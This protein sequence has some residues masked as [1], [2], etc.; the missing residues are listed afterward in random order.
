MLKLK[1]D[2]ASLRFWHK[3]GTQI[4]IWR[5]KHKLKAIVEEKPVHDAI[6]VK[7]SAAVQN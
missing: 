3:K 6:Q 4:K 1:V 5:K 7:N 2:P